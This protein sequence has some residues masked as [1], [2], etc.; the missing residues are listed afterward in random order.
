V[1]NHRDAGSA[2]L[3][4]VVAMAVVI[5]VAACCAAVGTVVVARHRAD[6]AADA[7][8]L[9]A[10]SDVLDGQPAACAAAAAIARVDGARLTRCGLDGADAQ[11]E[12]TASLPAQLTRFGSAVGAA[13]AGPAASDR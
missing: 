3:W 9:A 13:R 10:A 12:V 11:V 5:A 1:N 8:A 6:V 7:A 2:T 4:V